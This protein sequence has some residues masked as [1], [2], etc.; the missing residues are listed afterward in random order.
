M[1][2]KEYSV[3]A[4]NEGFGYFY[5]A[6]VWNDSSQHDG[7]IMVKG[8]PI[9]VELGHSYLKTTCPSPYRGFG[10][11]K[12]WLRFFWD[13]LTEAGSKPTFTDIV[14]LIAAAGH[15]GDGVFQPAD[16][17]SYLDEAAVTFAN[18]VWLDRLRFLGEWNGLD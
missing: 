9:D 5:A 6:F 15:M 17:Y 16:A 10:N 12:D 14:N 4:F 8:T 11:E 3:G 18:G 2:S 13:F 7:N 1:T